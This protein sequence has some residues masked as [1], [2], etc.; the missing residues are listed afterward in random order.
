[1]IEWNF[2][3]TYLLA[4]AISSMVIIAIYFILFKEKAKK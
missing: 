3:N 2:A 1:M 4:A